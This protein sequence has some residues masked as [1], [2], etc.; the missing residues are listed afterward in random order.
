MKMEGVEEVE[1]MT[2]VGDMTGIRAMKIDIRKE[3]KVSLL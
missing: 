2:E 3:R 1:D